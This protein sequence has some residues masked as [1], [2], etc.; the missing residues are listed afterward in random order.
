M[1]LSRRLLVA[2]ILSVV[3]FLLVGVCDATAARRGVRVDFLAWADETPIESCPGYS[4]SYYH[5]RLE[6]ARFYTSRILGFNEP[7]KSYSYCQESIPWSEGLDTSEYLNHDVFFEDESVL[8][9]GIGSNNS[10]NESQNVTARKYSYL[11]EFGSGYQF[12][13][14]DFP[15]GLT[16]VGYYD[17]A[18]DQSPRIKSADGSITLWDGAYDGE[19]FCFENG[20]FT[21]LS[22]GGPFCEDPSVSAFEREALV[23]FYNSTD[24]ANWEYNDNWLA[25]DPCQNNWY[26]VSCR[27]LEGGESE[28]PGAHT[29][30]RLDL[31]Y[32]S[33][34]GSIPEA[35]GNLNNLEK[36][37]LSANNLSG[38]IP[39]ALGNL[40]SLNELR[41][42]GNKLTG[43]IPD[44][45]ENLEWIWEIN[46]S[47]NGLQTINA[48]LD[49]IL[50]GFDYD[51]DWSITQTIPPTNLVVTAVGP[52][53]ISLAWNAIEY[54][55]DT[56][57]YRVWYS[58]S[59]S[60]PFSDGGATDSKLDTAHTIT[61]LTGGVPY[62]VIVR[63]ETDSHDYNQNDIVS[64]DSEL[65]DSGEILT[66]GFE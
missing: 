13:F 48:D 49:S 34:S 55:G 14:Y 66:D 54:T 62:Y 56:G 30:T 64:E 57:R 45:L 5:V 63:S 58:T 44:S 39:E 16:L 27:K 43:L 7:W 61:G 22:D 10:A 50:D 3:I 18:V 23:A 33:L 19:Y 15:G 46:L 35:L 38:N 6:N 29:V 9:D 36:L 37:L 60:G 11:S 8:A 20:E 31:N 28:E 12:T 52:T 32:N 1:L 25:G 51:G 17:S 42:G 53:S 4:Y 47:W 24:G 41:L 65:L 21:G 2:R 26:G 40:T 59:P